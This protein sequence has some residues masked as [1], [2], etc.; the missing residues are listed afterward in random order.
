[1]ESRDY[2]MENYFS[3]KNM[4][5][6][7]SI[8][9]KPGDVD[10]QVFEIADCDNCIIIIMDHISQLTIDNVTSCK[11]FIGAC[12]G[13]I[14]VRNCV[15]SS[16]YSCCHQMRLRECTDT[17]FYTYS[18]SETHIELSSRVCFGPFSGGY[19]EHAKHLQAGT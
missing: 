15:S 3:V 12:S 19:P 1:M 4:S 18:P 9:K 11:I 16:I 17:K 14:F 6:V 7:D 8:I 5:N 13:S 10:G 2:K